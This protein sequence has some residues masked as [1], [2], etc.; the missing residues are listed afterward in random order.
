METPIYQVDAFSSARFH[1]NPAAVCPLEGWLDDKTLQAIAG[2]NNLSETAFF[3]LESEPYPLRW[4][5]PVSEVDL[6]GH[7]TL[8]AAF[9][10]FEFINPSLKKVEFST[11]S[12]RLTV[13]RNNSLLAMDFPSRPPTACA[14][15]SPLIEGLGLEP[16]EV[17]S[18]RDYLAVYDSEE[19][20]RS[21]RP[22][23]D[24][25]LE[26]DRL[27]V[28]VTST[29]EDADFVS[30]F[31]APKAGVPEDPVTGSAHC[32]LV[33]Y[34]AKKAGKRRLRA[35]QLSQRGGELFCED[36]GERVRIAG[37]AV[38]YMRGSIRL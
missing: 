29:G 31:F 11:K 4:F 21:L 22:R 24:L 26:L 37:E 36:L 35:F 12:G 30:R 13:E 32:T 14:A 17:L 16:R 9:V 33:P 20:I 28:I 6:C 10:F 8:A 15:P 19:E 5:T 38:L 3:V 2:E 34:W 18:S 7:A 1:G 25:L 27:G 23:M